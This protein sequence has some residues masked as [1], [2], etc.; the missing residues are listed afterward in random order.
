MDSSLIDSFRFAR[1]P[2]GT[3]TAIISSGERD[4][5]ITKLEVV[6]IESK[7]NKRNTRRVLP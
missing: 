5:V 1:M 3:N 4:V 7:D 2:H 6:I